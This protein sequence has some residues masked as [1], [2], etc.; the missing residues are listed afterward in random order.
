M[1][2]WILPHTQPLISNEIISVNCASSS[3]Q[4]GTYCCPQGNPGY[5]FIGFFASNHYLIKIG[6][7]GEQKWHPHSYSR[8]YFQVQTQT[9]RQ[10]GLIGYKNT[11]TA[12]PPIKLNSSI[13]C[14]TNSPEVRDDNALS[15]PYWDSSVAQ[16]HSELQDFFHGSFFSCFATHFKAELISLSE[17]HNVCLFLFF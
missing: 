10:R 17:G 13:Y 5:V 12:Y 6:G 15:Q 9:K 11:I 1:N 2:I 7:G 16:P 14:A 3:F 8:L 4:Q